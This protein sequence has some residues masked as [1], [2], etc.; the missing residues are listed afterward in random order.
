MHHHNVPDP[1]L[2]R[3]RLPTWQQLGDKGPGPDRLRSIL[4][5]EIVK[6]FGGLSARVAHRLAWEERAAIAKRFHET[7]VRLGLA[8]HRPQEEKPAPLSDEALTGLAKAFL[9]QQEKAAP[10]ILLDQ[11]AQSEL[12]QAVEEGPLIL[13]DSVR[14]KMPPSKLSR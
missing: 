7:E 1:W 11:E 10:A 2:V 3:R 6:S 13:V 8:P 9:A 12:L 5:T 4:P 14:L